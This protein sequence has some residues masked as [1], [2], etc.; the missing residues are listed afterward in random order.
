MLPR[1][2]PLRARRF[3]IR[4]ARP[5]IVELLGT[6]DP[7]WW[8]GLHRI[9]ARTLLVSGGGTSHVS[10]SRMQ[11]MALEVPVCHLVTLA[12]AGHRAQ[13]AA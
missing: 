2:M 4:M 6:P 13:Q 3:D 12:G 11:R 10:R 8:A 9:S 1:A 7:G 5:V